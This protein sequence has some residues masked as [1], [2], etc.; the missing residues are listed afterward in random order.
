VA[1]GQA[2]PG[3]C[4]AGRCKERDGGGRGATVAWWRGCRI[5]GAGVAFLRVAHCRLR[6]ATSLYRKAHLDLGAT[7]IPVAHRR[8]DASKAKDHHRPRGGLG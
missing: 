1:W 7:R 8:P 3:A 4:V 5:G 2:L 6:S